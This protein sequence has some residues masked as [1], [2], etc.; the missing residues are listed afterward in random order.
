LDSH[1]FLALVWC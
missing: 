1:V